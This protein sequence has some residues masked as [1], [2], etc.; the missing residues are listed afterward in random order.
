VHQQAREIR[1]VSEIRGKRL[2]LE[3]QDA[4]KINTHGLSIE[5]RVE[6]PKDLATS[7]KMGVGDIGVTLE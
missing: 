1:L 6:V 3:L 4:P 5:L 7:V 2:N